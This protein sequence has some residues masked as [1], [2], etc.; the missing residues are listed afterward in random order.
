M[1]LVEPALDDPE[2]AAVRT[3]HE[4]ERVAHEGDEADRRIDPDIA[5]HAPKLE[6]RYAKVAAFPYQPGAHRG[7]DHVAEHRHQ[8]ENRVE[9]DPIADSGHDEGALEQALHRL[10][11]A[12]DR[13]GIAADRQPVGESLELFLRRRH[14]ISSQGAGR[15]NSP[16]GCL[17][18]ALGRKPFSR[19][20][21]SDQRTGAAIGMKAARSVSARSALASCSRRAAAVGAIRAAASI[22][23]AAGSQTML[24]AQV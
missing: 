13:G 3:E 2:V 16:A 12:A 17:P 18:N 14:G 24:A 8:A 6:A 10:E 20:E 11:P 23:S 21:T 4:V 15:S 9:P 7:G 1:V 19:G 5:G 22:S